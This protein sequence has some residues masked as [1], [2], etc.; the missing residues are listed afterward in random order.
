LFG[1][2]QVRRALNLIDHLPRNTFY[3][4]ALVNDEDF[5]LA[6]ARHTQAEDE[7]EHAPPMHTWSPEMAM[8]AKI[9]DKLSGIQH[10]VIAVNSK[11]PPS[12]PKPYPMPKTAMDRAH[13]ITREERH[14]DLVAKVL[15]RHGQKRDEQPPA[16]MG[17]TTETE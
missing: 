9:I 12:S 2:R 6:M 7:T 14:L 8:L 3:T 16:T 15:P 1:T 17:Q 13:R 11:T 4:E 10:A 5:A